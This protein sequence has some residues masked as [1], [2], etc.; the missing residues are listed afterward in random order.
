MDGGGGG[1][2]CVGYSDCGNCDYLVV[3]CGGV[4]YEYFYCGGY[5]GC[6]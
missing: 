4:G 2:F 3:G 1:R 5:C 6:V